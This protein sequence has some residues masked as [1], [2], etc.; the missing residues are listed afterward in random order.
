[1]KSSFCGHVAVDTGPQLPD[2]CQFST[3]KE[4]MRTTARSLHGTAALK[5]DSPAEAANYIKAENLLLRQA[6]L[7]S[8]AEE[9]KALISDQPIPHSS[10][11]GSLS[12]EY[13]QETGLL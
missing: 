8:F 2:V 6:Q 5:P 13:D 11:L 10:R 3:W 7:E 1:M 12:P 4:L 9:D